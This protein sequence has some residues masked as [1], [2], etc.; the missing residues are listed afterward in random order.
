MVTN[1]MKVQCFSLKTSLRELTDI[2]DRGPNTPPSS[3]TTLLLQLL[4]KYT[5]VEISCGYEVHI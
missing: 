1:I 4:S 2:W 5:F 3:V